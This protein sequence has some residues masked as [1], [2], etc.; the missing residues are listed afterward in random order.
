M[1]C[2]TTGGNV[3][4][5]A[6]SHEE[7][8]AGEHGAQ[9]VPK[10]A[11]RL[12]ALQR[13]IVVLDRDGVINHDSPD[14]IRSAAAFEPIPGSLDAIGQLCDAGFQLAIATNQSGI[15]R[16]YFSLDVLDQIHAKLHRLLP[17][18]AAIDPIL[19]C[20]LRPDERCPCRKPE[21]GM[22]LEIARRLERDPSD[23]CF[24]GD[25]ATDMEAARR[26]GARG[27][28]V[29]TGNGSEHLADRRIPPNVPVFDDLAAVAAALIGG[30]LPAGSP[31]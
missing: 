30:A 15:G 27:L 16:C 14:Y 1:A 10:G 29:R 8:S 19:F 28:L 9:L 24:V 21:P 26:A 7:A 4:E 11:E 12:T 17:A 22:L 6:G 2:D 25:S 3:V 5:N 20:P 31:R 13:P 18:G 23:L